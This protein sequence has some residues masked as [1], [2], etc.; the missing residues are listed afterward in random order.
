MKKSILE[1]E[2]KSA[3]KS[4]KNDSLVADDVNSQLNEHEDNPPKEPILRR[5]STSD[6][7]VP[8]LQELMSKNPQG[9]FVLRDEL[10]GFLTSM[11]Q[12][13]R[14]TDRAFHLEAWRVRV[15]LSSTELVGEL[16]VVILSVNQCLE[17]SNQ[18]G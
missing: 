2:L 16:Y 11:E 18:Q 10:H 17:A 8:K 5:Y 1:D 9:I 13:G 3:L 7:T 15:V 14:E 4:K 12:E 6:S